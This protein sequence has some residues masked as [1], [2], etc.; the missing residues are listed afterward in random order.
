MVL[1]EETGDTVTHVLCDKDTTPRNTHTLIPGPSKIQNMVQSGSVKSVI[2]KEAN[3][4]SRDEVVLSMHCEVFSR[5][6]T[7]FWHGAVGVDQEEYV[8][9]LKNRNERHREA[10]RKKKS[11]R[12]NMV[13]E[14]DEGS[15]RLKEQ[16]M[17]IRKCIPRKIYNARN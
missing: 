10:L 3:R 13:K 17:I 9:A 6:G 8:R 12:E 1:E 5:T 16:M 14:L 4:L 15:Q 7:N 2:V 11:K